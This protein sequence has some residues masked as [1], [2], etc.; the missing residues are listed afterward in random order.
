MH[1]G[2]LDP[3]Y[4]SPYDV[5]KKGEIPSFSCLIWS[6]RKKLSSPIMLISNSLCMQLENSSQRETLVA[7]KMM[8]STYIC[9]KSMSLSLVFMKRVVSIFPILKPFF[10]RNLLNLSYHA[11]GACFKP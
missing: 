2:L 5:A 7:Q 9:T 10:K 6:P 4:F 8:S 3:R 1:E 11:L